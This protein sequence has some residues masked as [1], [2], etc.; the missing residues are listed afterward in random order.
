M[1]IRNLQV[2][3]FTATP[4]LDTAT[5]LTSATYL[6]L[7]CA[8]STNGL[9]VVEIFEA[10]NASASTPAQMM[11]ARHH[12]IGITLTLPAPASDGPLNGL[13][14]PTQAQD[15]SIS[16]NTATTPPQR[17]VLTTAPRLNLGLN[18]F[19]G[20]LRWN[21]APGQEWWIIGVAVDIAE[22]S[23]SQYGVS[24]SNSGPLGAHIL[25]EPF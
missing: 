6:A 15:G 3:V 12:V 2:P 1:A 11:F 20:I 16:Y 19:G 23:L 7:G 17:S 9:R 5:T 22:S 25:Y 18:L 8:A 14:A 24:G 4:T 13:H 10:G 21:A